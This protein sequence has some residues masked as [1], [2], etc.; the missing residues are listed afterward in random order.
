MLSTGCLESPGPVRDAMLP[1]HPSGGCLT[2]WLRTGTPSPNNR[3]ETGES[4]MFV[5]HRGA[6]EPMSWLPEVE[7]IGRRK[8][9]AYKLG[10][11]EGVESS[12]Q[13][14]KTPRFVS[15]S[16]GSSIRKAGGRSAS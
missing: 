11:E 13:S 4:D 14:G 16:K 2:G 7:E 1:T 10:G 6:I 5:R 15:A 12:A 9:F 8:E 3:P